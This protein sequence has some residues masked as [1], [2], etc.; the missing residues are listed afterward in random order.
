MEL[1][2]F[3]GQP[4]AGKRCNPQEFPARGVAFF[5]AHVHVLPRHRAPGEGRF[6]DLID[7]LQDG[8]RRDREAHWR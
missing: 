6:R 8:I 4:R 3:A 1:A 2:R 5:A 7:D